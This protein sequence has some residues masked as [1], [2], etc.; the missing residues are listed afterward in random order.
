MQHGGRPRGV[1]LGVGVLLELSLSFDAA[2]S[3][4]R[5]FIGGRRCAWSASWFVVDIG[6]RTIIISALSSAAAPSAP[7]PKLV[8]EA[9]SNVS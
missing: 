9:L 7:H 8:S 1:L 5:D 2:R 6:S 4:P 3:V